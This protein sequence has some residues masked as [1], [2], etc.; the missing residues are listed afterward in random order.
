MPYI[1]LKLV[2]RRL[3]R[4]RPKTFDRARNPAEL[5]FQITTLVN[6]YLEHNGVTF[7][8]IAEVTGALECTKDEFL[9][10]IARPYEERKRIEQVTADH[11]DVYSREVLAQV[12]GRGE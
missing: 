7:Q 1:A 2:A 12:D 4:L 8:T 5:D 9:R 6:E 11:P 3:A 10:R